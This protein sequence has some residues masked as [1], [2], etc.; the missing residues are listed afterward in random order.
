[1]AIKHNTIV[2][3]A[4][5][6]LLAIP[7]IMM[8]PAGTQLAARG[9]GVSDTS[10]GITQ[11]ATG[12]VF[13]WLHIQRGAIVASSGCTINLKG[14]NLPET[15]YGDATGVL[16]SKLFAEIG[17]LAQNF[18]MN[19][20]RVSL[21]AVWW[22]E[23]VAVPMVGTHYRA[24]IQQL[25]QFLESKGSYVLLTKGPQFHEPPCGGIVTYC[26]SQNQATID[27]KKDPN[28]PVYQHQLTTGVYIDD[29]VTMW[30][31][32]AALYANDPAV[33]YDDWNEMH[34]ITPAL[35]R[36]NSQILIDTIR[37]QNPQSL[38][39]FGG[40]HFENG[41]NPL[42]KGLVPPFTEPNLVYD[43][44]VY[45]GFM[46]A[47]QGGPCD[48]P[49]SALWADWPVT[50]NI[51]VRY[52]QT[53]GGAASFSEWGGCSDVEPYNTDIT[54]FAATTH[55]MLAYYQKDDVVLPGL[56]FQLN[57]NGLKAQ[58]DYASY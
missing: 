34:Q 20:W 31:S 10:C 39:F 15:G 43:F 2:R 26:P 29:A 18:K 12:Y 1:M 25:V 21:N 33:L 9:R 24:W 11:T 51:Q 58:A 22:N 17:W 3:Y 40:N 4:F 44:H 14:F 53:H 37:S 6:F 19:V 7:L 54:Q 5:I 8:L 35:W 46:G 49:L 57:S 45:N 55:I 16:P 23:D 38:V 42:I 27:I 13:Q 28:N 50:A 41:F 32:V 47:F 56:P 36:Q 52:A 30:T 48:E